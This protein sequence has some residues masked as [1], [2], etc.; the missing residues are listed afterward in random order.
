[1]AAAA[2]PAAKELLIW[3]AIEN[4]CVRMKKREAKEGGRKECLFTGVPTAAT[5]AFPLARL[6]KRTLRTIRL[7]A[8]AAAPAI[9]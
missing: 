8:A 5:N 4:V 2:T 6:A 3:K 9:G 7:A 1:M